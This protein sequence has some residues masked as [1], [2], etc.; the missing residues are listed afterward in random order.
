MAEI[1]HYSETPEGHRLAHYRS[2]VIRDETI[3]R[4]IHGPTDPAL[5]R[6]IGDPLGMLQRRHEL[7]QERAW[8]ARDQAAIQAGK[9]DAAKFGSG[10]GYYQLCLKIGM[11]IFDAKNA[12]EIE[13]LLPTYLRMLGVGAA[14][15]EGDQPSPA[16]TIGALTELVRE[17][18]QAVQTRETAAQPRQTIDS[19]VIDDSD[20]TS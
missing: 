20:T 19:K 2:G 3:N 6:V 14:K 17:M 8:N 10:E 16:G 13:S 18:R 1:T 4:V 12:R 7:A 5:N 15:L 9:I 11:L